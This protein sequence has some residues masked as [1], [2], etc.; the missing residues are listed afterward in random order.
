M[1]SIPNSFTEDTLNILAFYIDQKKI[2]I[3]FKVNEIA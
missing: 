1:M 3:Y 2:H